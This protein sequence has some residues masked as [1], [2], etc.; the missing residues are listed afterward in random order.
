M[1]VEE[2]SQNDNGGCQMT[3]TIS[4]D[5]DEAGTTSNPQ[6]ADRALRQHFVD[7]RRRSR[8]RLVCVNDDDL[9]RNAAASRLVDARD[10]EDLWDWARQVI[11]SGDHSV[12]VLRIGDRE[13]TAHCEALL[14]RGAVIGALI[15]IDGDAEAGENE[16]PADR[17]AFGW[18]SLTEAELGVTELVTTGLTNRE[19]GARLFM[20]HH[21]VDS[22]LRAIYR[23]LQI[24]SR[25]EL[26]R[27]AV[28]RGARA[29]V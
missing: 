3:A 14:E 8:G 20:S 21:T 1:L 25:I 13:L 28:E 19:I 9:L 26:T 5:A 16:G 15:H 17:R 10:R 4:L 7:A 24:S 29:D 2:R 27:L 18:E 23:K 22:H 6:G 11:G 12:R